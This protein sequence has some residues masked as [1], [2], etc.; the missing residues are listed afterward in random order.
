MAWNDTAEIRVFSSGQVYVGATTATMP[1]TLTSTLS[2]AEW[3]GLGLINED[4]VTI[5]YGPD[6]EE[7]RAWQIRGPVR[8]EVTGITLT[9]AFALEQFNESTVPFAFGGGVVTNP[10]GS[11]YRYEFPVGSEALNERAL[12]IDGVDG[13]VH[14]RLVIKRGN[15]SESVETQ[16]Q[17]G[18]LSVLPIT[19][20]ALEPTDDSTIAYWL[21]DD[22][23]AFVAGS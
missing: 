14:N 21:S 13:A 10:S 8:R 6:I 1:T 5:T 19:F 2:A 18:A 16:F 4:G 7:F 12:V 23:A 9:A 17:R 3:T 22:A 20:S 15:V 11:V